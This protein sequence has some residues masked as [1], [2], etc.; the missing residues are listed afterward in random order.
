MNSQGRIEA[1]KCYKC[2]NVI[3]DSYVCCDNDC[4]A[5]FCLN[6]PFDANHECL[7]SL[8]AHGHDSVDI[9]DDADL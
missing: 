7:I 2:G 6:C 3:I 5:V 1:K 8:K 4:G 9:P